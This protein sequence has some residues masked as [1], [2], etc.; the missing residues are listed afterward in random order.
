[1][2]FLRKQ[3]TATVSPLEA[4]LFFLKYIWPNSTPQRKWLSPSHSRSALECIFQHL[5]V[6]VCLIKGG[7]GL[8]SLRCHFIS[9]NIEV[10]K[11]ALPCRT[12]KHQQSSSKHRPPTGLRKANLYTKP[13][14][15]L[16]QDDTVYTHVRSEETERWRDFLRVDT[17][18]PRHQQYCFAARRQLAIDHSVLV[19]PAD[20]VSS[21]ATLHCTSTGRL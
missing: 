10:C 2:H 3:L 15:K 7:F 20:Q 11:S 19:T 4:F 13:G 1:M 16:L 14:K 6:N 9:N 21:R 8:C 17:A 5:F 12:M 18:H